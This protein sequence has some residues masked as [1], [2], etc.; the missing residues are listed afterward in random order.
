MPEYSMISKDFNIALENKLLIGSKCTKCGSYAIPHRSICPECHSENTE[1]IYFSGNGKLVAFTVISVPPVI[2]AE[3]GYDS[4]NPYC[5]GIVE[6]EEGP[7]ISA[8]IVDVDLLNPNNIKIGTELIM[9]II[10]R[11]EDD[12]EKSY[13]A[14]KP[15]K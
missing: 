12:A 5:S 2:M 11:Q 14:F 4:K 6:L 7:R 15:V 13:L 10:T 9:S 1:L 3:A 8:Q